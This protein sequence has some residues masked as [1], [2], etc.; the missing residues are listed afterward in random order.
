MTGVDFDA[1]ARALATGRSRRQ[2]LKGLFGTTLGVGLLGSSMGVAEA[3]SSATPSRAEIARL[4]A[5]LLSRMP[6]AAQLREA[7]LPAALLA[8]I[9]TDQQLL[10]AGIDAQTW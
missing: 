7:H 4:S 3:E 2:A 8:A 6:D 5:Q 9:Q 10:H 1:L